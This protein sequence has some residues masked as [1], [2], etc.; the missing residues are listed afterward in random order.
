MAC[1]YECHPNHELLELYT[2]R[3][4]RCDCGNSRCGSVKCK[5]VGD[6]DPLNSLNKYNHNFEGVYCHCNQFDPVAESADQ[7]TNEPVKEGE[8]VS[9]EMNQCTICEDWLVK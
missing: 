7:G 2:K 3:D 6:K 9:E 8:E 4:F 1:S 5:L